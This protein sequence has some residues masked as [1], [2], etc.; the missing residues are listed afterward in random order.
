MTVWT[1][2]TDYAT[3]KNNM[4]NPNRYFAYYTRAFGSDVRLHAESV[5]DFLYRRMEYLEKLWGA[6]E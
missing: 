3:K 4:V 5:S 6:S 1:K 2:R